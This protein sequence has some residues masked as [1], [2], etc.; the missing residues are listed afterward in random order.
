[1]YQL[2]N[3]IDKL[4]F[5][6][7]KYLA[8]GRIK[9]ANALNKAHLLLKFLFQQRKIMFT[10]GN[11][12]SRTFPEDVLI[13]VLQKQLT[14]LDELKDDQIRAYQEQIRLFQEQIVSED[15]Q[16]EQITAVMENTTATPTASQTLHAGTIQRLLT[17]QRSHK[18]N[19]VQVHPEKSKQKQCFFSKFFFPKNE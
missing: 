14:L 18:E 15:R 5:I 1:M 16:I 17:E 19:N 3:H 2:Y 7:N 12:K 8:R 9:Q 13:E 11:K 4:L 6:Y 10:L